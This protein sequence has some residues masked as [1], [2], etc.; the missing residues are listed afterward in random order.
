MKRL[1]R[2]AI[3]AV[4]AVVALM[5][6]GA[7]V[8]RSRMEE[9][10]QR[11]QANGWGDAVAAARERGEPEASERLIRSSPDRSS[12][13]VQGLAAVSPGGDAD[14]ATGDGYEESGGAAVSD[15][16][17][18]DR[19]AEDVEAT[20]TVGG[21]SIEQI[22]RETTRIEP[23]GRYRRG[24]LARLRAGSMRIYVGGLKTAESLMN[25][26]PFV[27][28]DWGMYTEIATEALRLGDIETARLYLG[29]LHERFP[30]DSW[31]ERM[32]R[33]IGNAL[34]ELDWAEE[35]LLQ[36][37]RLGQEERIVPPPAR[38]RNAREA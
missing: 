26:L 23:I 36:T 29:Y 8:T 35:D 15:S 18:P 10:R 25:T 24:P 34:L 14:G 38:R 5:V 32:E 22:A 3:W 9:L 27:G 7:L 11:A 6:L 28:P 31:D 17:T 30:P 37:I 12:G 20:G 13:A 1:T 33:F 2:I 21:P 19:A 4:I 16:H